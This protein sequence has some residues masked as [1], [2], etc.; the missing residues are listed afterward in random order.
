MDG[1]L[2]TGGP[3]GGMAW[4]NKQ[5]WRGTIK[6]ALADPVSEDLTSPT[7]KAVFILMPAIMNGLTTIVISWTLAAN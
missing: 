7:G 4:F 1:K 3:V 2:G 6:I 5:F